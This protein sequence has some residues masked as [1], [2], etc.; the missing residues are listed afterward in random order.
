MVKSKPFTMR[1]SPETNEWV[2]REARRT[3]R[4]KGAIIEALA[5]EGI[6]MRRFPGIA[7]RGPDGDRR[8]WV[9]GSGLDVWEIIESYKDYGESLERLLADSD[10]AERLIR[11]ALLYYQAYPAEIDAAVMANQVA[12]EQAQALYPALARW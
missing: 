4:S 1:L 3:R 6:R 5:E 11:L 9:V 8:A 10:V 2:E 7:F 12:Q